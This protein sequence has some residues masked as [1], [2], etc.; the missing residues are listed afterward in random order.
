MT[1][2]QNSEHVSYIIYSRVT[3]HRT[4]TSTVRSVVSELQKS[5]P[6]VLYLHGTVRLYV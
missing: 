3:M 5:L 4:N 2:A 6:K 1:R